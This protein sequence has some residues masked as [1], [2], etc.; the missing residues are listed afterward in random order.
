MNLLLCIQP[1]F[2]SQAVPWVEDTIT[3]AEVLRLVEGDCSVEGLSEQKKD[4]YSEVTLSLLESVTIIKFI[5]INTIV[6]IIL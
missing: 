1:L 6:I 3:A 2:V 4:K 5:M